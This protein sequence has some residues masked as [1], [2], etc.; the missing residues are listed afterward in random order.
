ML[1]PVWRAAWPSSRLG[2]RSRVGRGRLFRVAAIR[3]RSAGWPGGRCP[4]RA[5]TS[6]AGWCS[7]WCRA[8]RASAGRRRTPVRS[9]ASWMSRVVGQFGAA[10]PGDRAAQMFGQLP[11]SRIIASATVVRGVA[12]G[13]VQQD[14]EP[15]RSVRPGCRSRSV[16]GAHD[17]V[18]FPMA[19][20]GPVGDLGRPLA[21]RERIGVRA[22][23]RAGRC[24][25]GLA[26]RR[27]RLS[28]WSDQPAAGRGSGHKAP[29]RS[30]R[31]SPGHVTCVVALEHLARSVR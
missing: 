20:H 17:Q 6:A 24:C 29:G 5:R 26:W 9:S 21:D 13:Q 15:G 25:P 1:R 10:V 11:I 4:S 3:C 18:A 30:S 2:S 12:A 7:R 31:G 22:R 27:F 23:C 19:G 14:R 16:P 28:C 8:A